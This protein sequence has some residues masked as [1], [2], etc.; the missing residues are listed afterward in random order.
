M[1]KK[2]YQG[3]VGGPERIKSKQ[4]TASV[5]GMKGICQVDAA[6]HHSPIKLV[7]HPSHAAPMAQ[8][9]SGMEMQGQKLHSTCKH[10]GGL[11]GRDSCG[12]IRAG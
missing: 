7:I 2:V 10:I 12:H 8:A 4:M 9:L 11:Q 1:G 5:P 3:A 6:V